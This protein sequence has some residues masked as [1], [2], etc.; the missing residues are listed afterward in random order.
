MRPPIL[1]ARQLEHELRKHSHKKDTGEKQVEQN[2]TW[3]SAQQAK[4]IVH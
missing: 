4:I 1:V 3:H 2:L